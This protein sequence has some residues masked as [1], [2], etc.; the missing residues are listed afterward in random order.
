[1]LYRGG[2]THRIEVRN[3]ADTVRFEFQGH[4]D[5][6]ALASL[7]AAV[8]FA[9][10]AGARVRV[11]LRA[12]AEVDREILPALRALD[13]SLEVESPYLARWLARDV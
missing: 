7:E 6:P 5:A 2:V 9:R 3:T 8:A 1:V 4:M 12:G 10:A 13:V 11:V